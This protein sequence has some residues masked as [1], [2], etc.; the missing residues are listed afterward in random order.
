MN[1]KEMRE[2]LTG[3]YF[4]DDGT[5]AKE[6]YTRACD[7]L[8][9]LYHEGMSPYEMKV[10]QYDTI[11]D[12]L[13]PVLFYTCPYYYETGTMWAHC[14][15]ARSFH[16][17]RH[18]G[19]W[20]HWKN[21]HL[22]RDQDPALMDLVERQLEE[23]LYNCAYN[24]TTQHFNF[25]TR[26]IFE[27]GLKGLYED[28]KGQL[29]S[30]EGEEKEFL[31]AVC[32]AMLAL[33]RLSEKFSE[34]ARMMMES[35]P[36]ETAKA[37]LERICKSA[38]RTP[39]E[40]P[41]TLYE[42]L[43]A[44]AFMRKALG[45]LE[46]IGPNTFGR[47]DMDLYPFY[48]HDI[49]AGILTEAEAYDLVA[50]FLLTWDLHHD[51]DLPMEGYSDHE[52]E[53]T[54]VLGGCD[55]NGAPLYNELTRMFLQATR[56]EV[57]IFPK[58]TCRYSAASPK[59]YLHEA[60]RAV[61]NGTSTLLFQNDDATIGATQRMGKTLK[62]ARD[63][64]ITGCWAIMGNGI[65]K[66]DDGFYL[67][68]LKVFE[69]TLHN[70]VDK[71]KKVEL[72]FA[73]VDDAKTFDELYKIYCD[74]IM[75]LFEERTR[76]TRAGGNIWNKVDPLPIFSSTLHD[77]IQNKKDYTAGGARYRDSRF[78]LVGFPNVVD[79]LLAIKELCFDSQ[80]YTLKEMLHAIRNNWEGCEQMRQDAKKCHGWGDG[81]EA[82]A[83]FAA[84]FNHDLF[85]MASTLTGTYGGKVV[86][87]HFTYTEI[88]FWGE[89]TL[90]TPDGRKSGE[91]IAQGLTP[92]RLK[93]IPA[94]TN[95]IN[96]FSKLDST[97]ISGNSVVNIILPNKMTLEHCEAFL[98]AVAGSAVQSLQ[99]NCTSVEQLRDAQKHPEKYPDLIVR[100][101]GFS[102]KFTSLSPEWQLEVLTRNFKSEAKRS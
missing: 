80:K 23:N 89:T 96:S 79:S 68:I 102:A 40:A 34:K 74:N 65:E 27:K 57:I 20:T 47:V 13:D 24:D 45:T 58:I 73:P 51:H 84:R 66:I 99:L 37:N 81:D 94:V 87:G 44:L 67:N 7:K 12:M 5:R 48:K 19:G 39:W 9:S 88:R 86:I 93:K 26:P 75:I 101:C 64:L 18:A 21:R 56:E 72:S 61:V 62:E 69:Y 50:K 76:I 14:D 90:A 15:G 70:R 28:A 31:T 97:E 32:S 30:A 25:N 29:E 59:E 41:E 52:L 8:D 4:T 85:E 82:A 3:F 33:K 63:Y 10:L 100:V 95:V 83:E 35:A 42:A 17:H 98:R 11:V 54:Y 16:G 77:C 60:C 1:Y 22:F 53:N 43:N 92:S 78:E 46:G 91:Y 36:D 38:A 71:M 2:E 49:E 55:E 6:F